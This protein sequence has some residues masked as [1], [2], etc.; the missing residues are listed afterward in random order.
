[1]ARQALRRYV[2]SAQDVAIVVDRVEGYTVHHATG[3]GAGAAANAT[4]AVSVICV[5]DV[6]CD[7][8]GSRSGES[9]ETR[10]AFPWVDGL[11]ILVAWGHGRDRRACLLYIVVWASLEIVH[12]INRMVFGA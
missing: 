10:R 5:G 11:I 8:D 9:V 4:S 1:V 2:V 6:D 3:A 7:G 12:L